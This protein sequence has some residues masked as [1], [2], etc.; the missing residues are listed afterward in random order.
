MHT[1]AQPAAVP[2]NLRYGLGARRVRLALCLLN[3]LGTYLAVSLRSP[4]GELLFPFFLSFMTSLALIVLEYKRISFA[5][6]FAMWLFISANVAF[7]VSAL[8]YAADPW[9]RLVSITQIV[10]AILSSY[11]LFLGLTALVAR[12]IS[13]VFFWFLLLL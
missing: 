6:V 9:R 4:S 1:L 10:V 5:V 13:R 3:L 12:T 8:P 2:I 11:G 7:L